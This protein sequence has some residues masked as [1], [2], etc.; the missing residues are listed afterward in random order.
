[1]SRCSSNV[2]GVDQRPEPSVSEGMSSAGNVT[3][4]S[5]TAATVRSEETNLFQSGYRGFPNSVG[6]KPLFTGFILA[7][8]PVA[9]PF[10]VLDH[11]GGAIFC[12]AKFH[13]SSSTWLCGGGITALAGR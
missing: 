3:G 5:V 12:A 13:L 4:L 11:G 2:R 6:E 9:D 1:M 8:P 10:G 7:K